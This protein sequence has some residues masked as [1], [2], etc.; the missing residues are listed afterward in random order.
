M[1]IYI[2]GDVHRDF[3]R[4][5]EFTKKYKTTLNDYLIILGDVGINYYLDESDKKLK[6]E[7]SNL[8]IN[9]LCIQGNHEERPE[10]ISSYKTFKMFSGDVFIENKYPNLIFLKDGEVYNINDQK[11]LVIGGAYSI[12]KEYRI[13][14]GYHW[15]KDEQPSYKTKEKV[16]E[17]INKDNNIDIILTHTC[18]L[19]Y[20]PI[21]A[22]YDGIDQKKVDKSTEYFLEEV[23]K[24]LNYK[25]WY[26]GHFHINKSIYKI[27]FLFDDIRG[28]N[29]R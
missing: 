15:F 10:N 12:D 18:P 11:V 9:L 5:Y 6:E 7:L 16:K 20:E 21:E 13:R 14:Y 27:I 22:F 2:T 3:E 29:E 19:K 8:P 26:C 1:M 4:I 23:E 24:K 28:F 25:K 17:V